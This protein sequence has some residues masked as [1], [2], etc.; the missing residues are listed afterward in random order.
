MDLTVDVSPAAPN[1]A[2]QETANA[3]R[4]LSAT[5]FGSYAKTGEMHE[6]VTS[7]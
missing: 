6:I 1:K 4:G 2:L 3:L 5:E 7:Y